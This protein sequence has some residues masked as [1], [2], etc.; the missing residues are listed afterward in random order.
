MPL[1][2]WSSRKTEDKEVTIPNINE[3]KNEKVN[4]IEN[5]DNKDLDNEHTNIVDEPKEKEITNPVDFE[6]DRQS[7]FINL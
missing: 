2:N 6:I 3:T 4:I 1:F 7:K 5:E